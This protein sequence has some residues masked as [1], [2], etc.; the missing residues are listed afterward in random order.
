MRRTVLEQV[1]GYDEGLIA[2][3]EPD[4][5]R[6][7]RERGW[8]ILHID[9]LMTLHDLAMTRW[10]QYWRRATRTGYA[11]AQVSARYRNTA[12]PFWEHE[13]K[14]NIQR[15]TFWCALPPVVL[16]VSIM[17]WTVLPVLLAGGLFL[18][19]SVRSA[20]NF[21][22]KSSDWLTLI[23]YGFHSHIQHVPILIGQ[24]QYAR[25]MRAGV[26]RGL[27]EYKETAR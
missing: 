11:Y 17:N 9:D 14:H 12:D 10:S 2:G 5:C 23:L 7:M 26:R 27:I 3:E 4:M 22:W 25:D 19:L 6:R 18:L 15:G 13:R 16:F 8:K 20:W 24:R 1:N 21:R